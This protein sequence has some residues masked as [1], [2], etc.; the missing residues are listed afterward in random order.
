MTYV[1]LAEKGEDITVVCVLKLKKVEDTKLVTYEV[2]DSKVIQHTD[3]I[4]SAII[5]KTRRAMRK[6]KEKYDI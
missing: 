6:F 4:K 1:D 3:K 2:I 5:V